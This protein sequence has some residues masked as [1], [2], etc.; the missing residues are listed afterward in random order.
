MSVDAT[1]KKANWVRRAV[2]DGI[3]AVDAIQKATDTNLDYSGQAFNGGD[4]TNRAEYAITDADLVAA[5]FP[6]LTAAK[7]NAFV[8]GVAALKATLDANAGIL[9]AA[10]P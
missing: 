3:A 6:H 7:L 1:A 10:R 4:M 5:G 9:G 2:T 8:G